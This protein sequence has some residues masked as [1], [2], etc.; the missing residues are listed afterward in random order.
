VPLIYF[1]NSATTS[2][3]PAAAKAA[4][5][6]MLNHWGNPDSKYSI[7]K[8]AKQIEDEATQAVKEY[9]GADDSS[10][11]IF[12]SSG[13]ESN[14]LA[15]TGLYNWCAD[16][17]KKCVVISTP[18]EHKSIL[19]QPCVQPIVPIDCEGMVNLDGLSDLLTQYEN[20]DICVVVSVMLAS[21]ELG[22]INS[23]VAISDIC[24]KHGA[25]FHCDATQAIGIAGKDIVKKSGVDMLT[26]SGHKI[27]APKG[28]GVLYVRSGIDLNPIIYGG[29]QMYGLRGG[30]PNTPYMAA[31]TVAMKELDSNIEHLD[32]L[33]AE[34]LI[35]FRTQIID[36]I[37]DLG[38]VMSLGN[39]YIRIPGHIALAIKGIDGEA[40]MAML[41]TDSI[42]IS[43]GSACNSKSVE[44]SYVMRAIG[45][46]DD[47]I[48]GVVRIT[49]GDDTTQEQVDYLIQCMKKHIATLRQITRIKNGGV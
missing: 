38:G 8:D 2:V 19:R 15:L 13:S 4:Y 1:D 22:T 16:H 32:S 25:I 34:T 35:N 49:L 47:Y 12:T 5:D 45:V 7:G 26:F 40:L 17:N 37:T 6:V 18:I 21:N 33:K 27:H 36:A 41:D 24:H 46:P 42:C 30:T 29:Q 28:I 10:K 3:S 23:A 20:K 39:P 44:P 31:L 43:T 9:L 48:Y 11:V 14:N